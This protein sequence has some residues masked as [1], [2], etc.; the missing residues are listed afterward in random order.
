MKFLQFW[1]DG[2]KQY[3][4]FE[5]K[6]TRQQF[7]M[8]VLITVIISSVLGAIW[9]YLGWIFDLAVLVP[10]LAI[11]ARRLHD[12]NKSGWLQLLC[13]IPFVG[14]LILIFGF[15]IKPSAAAA[16]ESNNA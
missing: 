6:A 8:Y 3:A 12:I 7:W 9:R 5:G 10:S 2:I 1:L 4:N 11:G 15:W 14:A 13:L 16:T